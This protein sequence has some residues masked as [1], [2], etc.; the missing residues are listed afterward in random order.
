MAARAFSFA[1]GGCEDGPFAH[2]LTEL[3]PG[4]LIKGT[5][6]AYMVFS[7]PVDTASRLAA[8]CLQ[9]DP[10]VRWIPIVSFRV[11]VLDDARFIGSLRALEQRVGRPP[12]AASA[13]LRQV[14]GLQVQMRTEAVTHTL[15]DGRV[16]PRHALST[17]KDVYEALQAIAFHMATVADTVEDFLFVDLE[18]DMLAWGIDLVQV[19]VGRLIFVFDTLLCATPLNAA[20]VADPRNPTNPEEAV[21]SLRYWLERVGTTIVMQACGNDCTKLN[22]CY[23]IQATCVFDTH[24]ADAVITGAPEGRGLGPIT[25]A[26]TGIV[27]ELKDEMTHAFGKFKRRPLS[28][29]LLDYAWQDVAYGPALYRSMR[30]RLTDVERR[31]TLALSE[32]RAARHHQFVQA[33]LIAHDETT[34]LRVDGQIPTVRVEGG[35][36]GPLILAS[37]ARVRV[38]LK[39]LMVDL[40]CAAEPVVRGQRTGARVRQVQEIGNRLKRMSCVGKTMCAFAAHGQLHDLK[41]VQEDARCDT[42][43]F[44]ELLRAPDTPE[45]VITAASQAWF[46]SSRAAAV[47]ARCAVPPEELAAIQPEAAAE[48]DQDGPVLEAWVAGCVQAASRL[49]PWPAVPLVCGVK[50]AAAADLRYAAVKAEVP[51]TAAEDTPLDV[52]ELTHTTVVVHDGRRCLLLRRSPEARTAKVGDDSRL[53]LPR[54]STTE[55]IYGIYKAQHT[56]Q[57]LLGPLRLFP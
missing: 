29:F 22:G 42:V 11:T 52:H 28:R 27:M 3:G 33:M 5:C 35:L 31:I 55:S 9:T 19:A 53:A 12:T 26:Y 6:T 48:S 4:R 37:K 16:T 17:E 57:M 18:Y 2:A 40:L 54:L 25:K 32:H 20:Y 45:V 34:M 38:A 7:C 50:V 14:F 15:N 39:T 10:R 46:R 41:A 56:V 1:L 44:Q 13:Q 23:R 43:T 30:C 8:T 49:R 24:F 51:L 21:P 47:T 36:S